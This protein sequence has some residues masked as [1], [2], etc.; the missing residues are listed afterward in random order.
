MFWVK[1]SACS[2][3][4]CDGIQLGRCCLSWCG[5]LSCFVFRFSCGVSCMASV[6]CRGSP[7]LDCEPH[8]R[9][10]CF[11]PRHVE[12]AATVFPRPTRGIVH[13]TH[14]DT[15]AYIG[16]QSTS[17]EAET[18]WRLDVHTLNMKIPQWFS[19]FW[20]AAVVLIAY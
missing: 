9:F 18:R 10:T 19:M 17:D 3:G 12:N 4:T 6:C 7:K 5:V 16:E 2:S 15:S 8:L 20:S 11:T 1:R 13:H 14:T